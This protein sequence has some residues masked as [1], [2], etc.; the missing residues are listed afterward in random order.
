MK[1]LIVDTYYPAYQRGLYVQHPALASRSYQEQQQ[2]L[3]DQCFGTGDFYSSNLRRLGHEAQE[4]VANCEPLQRQWAR[5]HGLPL[6]TLSRFL[7]GRLRKRWLLKVLE[8]QVREIKPDILYVQDLNWTEE[9]FLQTIRPHVKLVMGQ[10]AYPLRPGIDYGLYDVVLTS[11]PHYVER[12]RGKG[13]AAEYFRIGFEPRVLE[14]LGPTTLCHDVVFV[15]G[16]SP[17]HV[18]GTAMLEQA[19][20]ALPT[21]IWGYGVETLPPDSPIRG[22]HHGEAWALDMYRILASSKIA[23]NRHIGIAENYANNM[24]LY[25]ATGAGALLLTDLKDNL[26]DLFQVGT[27]VVA[28]RDVE[29]CI[30]L[31]EYYLAHE[32][33]RSAIAQAGQRRTL[34]EHTYY[35]RMQELVAIA[36]RYL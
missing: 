10:T 15:G 9:R 32:D 33:E 30:R 31:A 28:Y 7:P 16:I 1:W 4:V 3:M 22:C 11:L 36:E 19:A 24:R 12:L 21:D 5:E 6:A 2:F 13:V 17:S 34:T 25:E 18:D 20:R 8:A 23:L 26:N 35:H 14:R 27:E 29:D